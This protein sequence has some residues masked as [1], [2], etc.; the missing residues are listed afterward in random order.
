M[1]KESRKSAM[2]KAEG[3]RLALLWVTVVG[4]VVVSAGVTAAEEPQAVDST[5]ASQAAIVNQYCVT[6][7]SDRLRAGQLVLDGRDLADIGADGVVWEKVISKLRGGMMPPPRAPRPDASAYGA[8]LAWLETG[9]DRAADSHPNP[10]RTETLHRLNRAEYGNAVRDLLGLEID[11]TELLPP[12]DASYGFDNIAGVLKLNQSLMERYLSAAAKVTRAAIGDR[13]LEELSATYPVPREQSQYERV[14]GLP[15]GTRGGTLIRHSFPH[16][17]TYEIKIELLCTTEIDLKCDAAGGF[18]QPFA[19][20]L[21]LDGE[22]LHTFSLDA[23][24]ARPGYLQEWDDV[25]KV[26][27]PIQ[28]GTRDV[29]VT[30][31]KVSAVEYVRR[32]LR[33]RFERPYRYYPD[34]MQI[35][36]PFIDTVRIVGPYDSAGLGDT[37]SR[38]RIFSCWPES[39]AVDDVMACARSILAPLVRQAYRRP[40]TDAELVK[41]LRFFDDGAAAGGFEGGIELVLRRVL[42]SA[43]F[44]FRVER[45]PAGADG[46]YAVTDLELASRLS[47]FLW[48]SLPDEELIEL[49]IRSALR[50]PKTLERQVRRML[51]DDRAQALV[52][53]FFGQWLKLRHV[54]QLQPSEAM[55]PDFDAS[56]QHAFKRETELF[57]EY[58]IRGDRSVIDLLDADYTFVN[59]RLARHYAI[60]NVQGASFRR[61]T[62]PDDRRR[63]LLGHGSILT[64]TS[65]AIR[66]SP[67][68]RGKWIL[69]NVLGTPPPNPPANVPPL[70]EADQASKRVLSMRERMSTHRANP[71]C[72]ACHAMIDPAGFALENFNAVGQWRDVDQTFTPIDTAGTLPDGTQFTTLVDFKAA[73]MAQPER[74]VQ[75]M[76][77]KL[78]TYALGRGL[79][80]YDQPAVRRIVREAGEMDYRFSTLVMGVVNS[81]PFRM[82]QPAEQPPAEGTVEAR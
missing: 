16:D 20:E 61:V 69:E 68:I 12:D 21:L 53:N 80:Y 52:E 33:K 10:G 25:F 74:F 32:G 82:R 41:L 7:H 62:Y 46:P 8:L 3:A 13:T 22:W 38:R 19:L 58:I 77:E 66:T 34:Q 76:T 70:E 54:D 30:F 40:V 29:G 47:F 50:N 23:T 73:L 75:N 2:A 15:F 63:G 31:V 1:M 65:H 56:L 59:G 48:S 45:D 28:A 64:L 72:A 79:E 44:L 4:V 24:E 51:V 37:P 26:R 60:P 11:V 49:A 36:E 9:L 39:E 27:V 42:T 57:V 18:T 14:E 55:F 71:V 81:L 35:A 17:G 6:C 43:D 78:L 67:V 5:A